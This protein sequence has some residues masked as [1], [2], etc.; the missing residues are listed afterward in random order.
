MTE[1]E[2]VKP[3]RLSNNKKR[4]LVQMAREKGILDTYRVWRT[5]GNYTDMRSGL[6][7]R[8]AWVLKHRFPEDGSVVPQD[9]VRVELGLTTR[10]GLTVVEKRAIGKLWYLF[11]K[12]V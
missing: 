6:T 3:P 4:G 5:G 2:L 1:S 8:E 11:E 9:R 7:D 10:Q 12:S